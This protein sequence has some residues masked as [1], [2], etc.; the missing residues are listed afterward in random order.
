MLRGKLHLCWPARA[1]P[2]AS[3]GLRGVAWCPR[4][5]LPVFPHRAVQDVGCFA[6]A[7]LQVA[8]HHSL[9]L[10]CSFLHPTTPLSCGA[11][12]PIHEQLGAADVTADFPEAAWQLHLQ[13]ASAGSLTTA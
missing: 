4:P 2:E 13:P 11:G 10:V 3:Q 12:S 1:D 8:L 7:V 9:Q 6:L 5:C